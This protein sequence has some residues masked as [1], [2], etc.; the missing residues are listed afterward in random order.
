MGTGDGSLFCT[1]RAAVSYTTKPLR[2]V[3]LKS[4]DA[5]DLHKRSRVGLVQEAWSAQTGEGQPFCALPGRRSRSS[6]GPPIDQ[7]K[8]KKKKKK[9]SVPGGDLAK[10]HRAVC[11]LSN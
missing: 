1:T 10:V 9:Y 7:A 8:K 3:D 11:M 5:S 2:T 4:S 6:R